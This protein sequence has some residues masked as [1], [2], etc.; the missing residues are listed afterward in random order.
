M[1]SRFNLKT[2]IGR[3]SGYTSQDLSLETLIGKRGETL[4][5]LHPAGIAKV[6]GQRLDVVSD[7]VFIPKGTPIEVTLVNSNRIVVK[8]LQEVPDAQGTG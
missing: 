5:D 7:G 4:S 1:G 3:D 6:D 8:K 2:Q